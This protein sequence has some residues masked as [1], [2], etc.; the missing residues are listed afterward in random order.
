LGTKT[1]NRTDYPKVTR[2]IDCFR[3]Q[4]P[5]LKVIYAREN[6]KEQGRK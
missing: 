6:G 5:N 4:F 1:Q 3:K 2:M